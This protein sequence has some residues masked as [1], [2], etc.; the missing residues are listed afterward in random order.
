RGEAR[1]DRLADPRVEPALPARVELEERLVG[2]GRLRG[3]A[4][5]GLHV[6]QLLLEPHVEGADR[7]GALEPLLL[8]RGGVARA[9]DTTYRQRVGAGL[10][11]FLARLLEDARGEL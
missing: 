6:G 10:E 7:D 4:V 1:G 8:L 3:V 5:R 11:A 9:L 2:E